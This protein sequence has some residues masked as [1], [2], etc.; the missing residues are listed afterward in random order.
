MAVC[1]LQDDMTGHFYPATDPMDTCPGWALLEAS[2]Y[3]DFPTLID[4][5]TIPAASDLGEMWAVGFSLPLIIY[6]TA[7]GY[8]VA[9]K[10]IN[11]R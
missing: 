3:T 9:V 7:W 11:Q 4:V 2:E 6:L 10:F 5:F 8:G 1:V